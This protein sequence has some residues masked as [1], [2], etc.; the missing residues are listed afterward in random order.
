[1][2][3]LNHREV[4]PWAM[5]YSNAAGEALGG[6]GTGVGTNTPP[7]EGG[8]TI[9]GGGAQTRDGG[10]TQ[11]AG[12]GNA[13]GTPTT[14]T[15]V[16]SPTRATGTGTGTLAGATNCAGCGVLRCAY[17]CST[18]QNGCGYCNQGPII[19]IP[20]YG[21]LPTPS[22]RT[23]DALTGGGFGGGGGGQGGEEEF[24]AE[25]GSENIPGFPWLLLILVGAGIYYLSTKKEA[26]KNALKGV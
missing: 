26:L 19:V 14:T 18:D 16:Y 10:Q 11:V 8:G 3:V 21:A 2:D 12:T 6:T 4:S 20:Q 5:F 23:L 24:L 17:G 15:P 9:A 22:Q 13:T 25:D 1:M 7:A